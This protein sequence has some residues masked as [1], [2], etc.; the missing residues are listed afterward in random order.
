LNSKVEY[1]RIAPNNSKTINYQLQT[2]SIQYR[3]R[4]SLMNS[5]PPLVWI[6]SQDVFAN[7]ECET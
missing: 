1:K 3:S 2:M 6:N 4:P 7:T 5:I